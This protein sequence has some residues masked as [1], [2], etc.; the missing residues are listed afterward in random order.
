M[1]SLQ[2][3]GAGLLVVA[4][5]CVLAA[6]AGTRA[7]Y[8][9]ADTLDETAKVVSEH[10]Y[11]LLREAN[12]LADQGAPASFVQRAQELEAVAAP[13]ILALRD[14]AQAYEAVRSA[15]NEGEL[16]AALGEAVPL[17]SQFVDLI[18][19]R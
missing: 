16:A 17:V 8:D 1:R 7:A 5:A 11:A 6:C 2:R 18:R 15:E 14:A 4:A 3:L 13:K 12:D 19:E 9:A 10:Y